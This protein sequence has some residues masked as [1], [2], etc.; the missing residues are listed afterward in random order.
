MK[1]IIYAKLFIAALIC[2]PFLSQASNDGREGG[3]TV[4][5]TISPSAVDV[6]TVTLELATTGDFVLDDIKITSSN[7]DLIHIGQISANGTV[8]S[9]D[10]V[11]TSRGDG[12]SIFDEI[13]IVGIDNITGVYINPSGN[14]STATAYINPYVDDM[15]GEQVDDELDAELFPMSL[16]SNI[17]QPNEISNPSSSSGFSM[18]RDMVIYP[19]PAR[20]E[21]GVV[22]VG[23]I[24]GKSI[25][26]M[27]MSGKIHLEAK[28]NEG[29]QKTMI[30]ITDLPAGIYLVSLTAYNGKTY[31]QKLYKVDY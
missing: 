3:T 26:V 6:N 16:N 30:D 29:S 14:T 11:V 4:I 8:I 25:Q 21:V 2:A 22:T 1:R 24:L 20:D 7:P 19:N 27:D 13:E 18:V 12:G 15:N 9:V 28:V 10:V 17:S 5:F 31:I 23:E